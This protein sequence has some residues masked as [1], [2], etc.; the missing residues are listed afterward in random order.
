MAM[1][2]SRLNSFAL[3]FNR[4]CNYVMRWRKK[5]V[6]EDHR[7]TAAARS[8]SVMKVVTAFICLIAI[9]HQPFQPGVANIC[10]KNKK[11]E[12]M[13]VWGSLIYF[14][15]LSLREPKLGA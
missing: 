14:L 9:I 13:L 1:G 11:Y 15:K 2:S 12:E 5:I 4:K 10:T 7:P 6:Q 8:Q 3:H